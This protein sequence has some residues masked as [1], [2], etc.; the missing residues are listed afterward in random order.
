MVDASYCASKHAMNC[1]TDALRIELEEQDAPISV[2]FMK[3]SA[4]DTPY[5][6]HAKDL[7]PMDQRTPTKHS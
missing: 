2:T 7:L 1:Y 4:I 6:R 5:I 3:P